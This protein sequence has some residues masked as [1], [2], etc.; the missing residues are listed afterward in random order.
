MKL[1]LLDAG[2]K[3]EKKAEQNKIDWEKRL[4]YWNEAKTNKWKYIVRRR[5][6]ETE[7]IKLHKLIRRKIRKPSENTMITKYRIKM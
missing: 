6:K 1:K 5:E 3:S 7:Y 2:M 4:N